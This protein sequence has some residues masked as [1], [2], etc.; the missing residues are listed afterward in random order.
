VDT[1]SR[2][3]LFAACA[4]HAPGSGATLRELMAAAGTSRAMTR[5]R[6]RDLRRLGRLAIVGERRV[7][8][9]NRP[10]AEYAVPG[11]TDAPTLG[12]VMRAWAAA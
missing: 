10:V 7:A 1:V 9:R 8:Y 4:L 6:V 2:A 3:L 5:S 12:D 11:G